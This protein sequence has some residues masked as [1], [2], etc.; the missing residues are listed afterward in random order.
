MSIAFLHSD[1]EMVL[2]SLDTV[3]FTK[4]PT[5][6]DIRNGMNQRISSGGASVTP[7]QFR[8]AVLQGRSFAP[9]LFEGS[10][11]NENWRVQN[12]VCLDFDKESNISDFQ[13]RCAVLELQP[14][15]I[16]HTFTSSDKRPKFRA[17]FRLDGVIVCKPLRDLVAD[18]FKYLFPT[19]DATF[20]AGRI[21]FGTN[22][23]A[24]SF[25]PFA[26]VSIEQLILNFIDEVTLF[27]PTHATRIIK[28]VFKRSGIG[29]NGK[30]VD[31]Q[32][33]LPKASALLAE[34]GKTITPPTYISRDCHHFTKDATAIARISEVNPSK[35]N[36]CN[37]PPAPKP[38]SKSPLDSSEIGILRDNCRLLRDFSDGKKVSHNEKMTLLTNLI[39]YRGGEKLF[40]KYL[41]ASEVNSDTKRRRFRTHAKYVKDRQYH[42]WRCEKGKCPYIGDC[43]R[44]GSRP[45]D[46]FERIRCGQI[47]MIPG[48]KRPSTSLAVSQ[49]Q[50]DAAIDEAM[51]DTTASIHVICADCG[52]GKTQALLNSTG[53][54]RDL[55]G[56]ILAVPTHRLVAEVSRRAIQNMFV[57]PDRPPIA[58]AYGVA[59]ERIENTGIGSILPLLHSYLKDDAENV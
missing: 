37:I 50:V 34:L 56:C 1:T 2:C 40:F 13:L 12:I 22:R 59:L 49:A 26:V 20:D 46:Q 43:H 41:D 17:C 27:D 52:I 39:P 54:P 3:S 21:F 10:R 4:K 33:N 58:G 7:E 8:D 16:Y 6:K 28:G 48:R 51:A 55:T 23:T 38:H 30:N 29:V 47:E 11:S 25:D 5:P 53:S 9:A 57:W 32:F 31:I 18:V 44:L 15:F 35:Q 42:P 19:A 45:L 36:T 14:F 24:I